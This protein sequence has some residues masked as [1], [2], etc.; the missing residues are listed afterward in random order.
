M[1][2]AVPGRACRP[3]IS[4]STSTV[5]DTNQRCAVRVTAADRMRA[6]PSSTFRDSLPVSSRVLIV[7][8]RGSV[9]V[10]PPQRMT[11]GPKRNE[12]RAFPFRLRPGN[13]GRFPLRSPLRDLTK[14]FSARSRFRNASWQAHL[15]FPARHDSPA[16][17]FF[18]AFRSL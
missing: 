6:A 13:P 9:T 10:L 12:S 4:R 1:P 2:V 7:P 5:N 16:P 14:S 8:R 3:G 18:S 11:P 15:E 17:A